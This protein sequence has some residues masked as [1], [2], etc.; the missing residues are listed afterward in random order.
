M[1]YP[2]RFS[3]FI[4]P[5]RIVYKN[6]MAGF[7]IR[8]PAR[9]QVKKMAGID[10]QVGGKVLTGFSRGP[11]G[12]VWPSGTPQDPIRVCCQQCPDNRHKVGIVW[13]LARKPIRLGKLNIT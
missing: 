4:E 3:E 1:P 13:S 5:R 8:D 2:D 7:G 6:P 12:H 11:G 10:R 9:K